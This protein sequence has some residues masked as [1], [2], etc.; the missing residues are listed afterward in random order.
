M[1]NLILA[2]TLM[3]SLNSNA[4]LIELAF[5][6]TNY[7][8]NEQITGQLIVSDLSYLL[9][10]FAGTI[11]FDDNALSLVNWTFGNGFDDGNGSSSYS[12]DSTSGQL[13]L[14]DYTDLM[15]DELIIAGQQ[16]TSF[17]LASFSFNSLTTGSHSIELL[18]GLEVISFDNLNIDNFEQKSASFMV[19]SVPEPTTALLLLASLFLLRRKLS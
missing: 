16:G 15:A 9:G 17:I 10:G 2:F 19:N 1:K 14:D 11:S 18:A 12:D 4:T 3:F 8:E 13:Y 5:D 6:K 7:A